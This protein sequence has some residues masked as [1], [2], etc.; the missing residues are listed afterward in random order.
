MKQSIST[1]G[2]TNSISPSRSEESLTTSEPVVSISRSL[3]QLLSHPSN[4]SCA[5]CR[6][7]LVDASQV[8]VSVSPVPEIPH[9]RYN[10]FLSNHANFA[11]PGQVPDGGGNG[12]KRGWVPM[13]DNV[14][15]HPIDPA[16]VVASRT[17]G[18]GVFICAMCAAAHKLLGPTVAVVHAVQDTSAPWTRSMVQFLERC[19]GNAR[20]TTVLEAHVP[21]GWS[22]PRAKSSIADR[23]TFIRAK[24]EALAFVLPPTGPIAT[25]A[26]HA[27]V[28]RHPEWKGL[29][30]ADLMTISDLHMDNV[31]GGTGGPA[32]GSSQSL[33]HLLVDRNAQLPNRLVDHFLVIDHSPYLAQPFAT[34]TNL[35]SLRAPEDI[36]L[37]PVVTDCYPEQGTHEDMEF[38]EHIGAFV[39]PEGYR[40]SSMPQPPTFFTFVL[41]CADGNRL[42]GGALRVY[43]KSYGLDVLRQS[44]V[45]SGYTD[46]QPPWLQEG[47]PE[48]SD[49]I[50]LPKCLLILSHHPFFDL[51]RKVLQV[52]II[53]RVGHD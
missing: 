37:S 5:D 4:R 40:P 3:A 24:Y 44:F 7:T 26:W 17:G 19:G 23:L 2:S 36:V 39:C 46:Q 6:V 50:Y 16:L 15:D 53:A 18:H 10:H 28:R 22:H 20:A 52:R 8:Y 42:Y 33:K 30:G 29:W 12:T 45:N 43:D 35:Q 1:Q 9:A 41:T 32:T 31:D 13:N 34:H 38:P 21:T 47:A 48:A 11:P 51:W 14:P 27:I 25:R 49:I